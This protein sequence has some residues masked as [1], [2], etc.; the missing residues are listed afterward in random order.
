[1]QWT[2]VRTHVC[3]VNLMRFVNKLRVLLLVPEASLV[4]F[5]STLFLLVLC[6]SECFSE[7][8]MKK[9]D[10]ISKTAGYLEY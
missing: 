3:F 2:D 8:I 10:I 5:M 6:V 4:V 7:A 1:M 9:M